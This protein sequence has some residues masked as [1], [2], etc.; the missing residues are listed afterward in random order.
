MY[1][2]E[3]SLWGEQEAGLG[4]G[5]Q[6]PGARPWGTRD[7]LCGRGCPCSRWPGLN[8]E[9]EMWGLRISFPEMGSPQAGW[10]GSA[11]Q[12]Q[13]AGGMLVSRKEPPM[14]Q[15]GGEAVGPGWKRGLPWHAGRRPLLAGASAHPPSGLLQCRTPA[16]LSGKG[17]RALQARC[18]VGG[19]GGG[20]LH[21]SP[22]RPGRLERGHCSSIQNRVSRTPDAHVGSGAGR[23]PL[24]ALLPGPA[25]Q[26]SPPRSV[27]GRDSRC[28]RAS[29]KASSFACF[30][31][32]RAS[33]SSLF[34][35]IRCT[36]MSVVRS[37]PLST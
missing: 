36:M 21:A 2:I 35:M 1:R 22:S 26:K 13:V 31:W 7:T 33:Y 37:F 30:F 25:H 17:V 24:R 20:V 15:T 8:P 12:C 27:P 9:E 11:T 3:K 32:F 28:L 34:L 5:G 16:Q 6:G 18:L 10:A 4:T 29:R 14:G 23:A 19:V